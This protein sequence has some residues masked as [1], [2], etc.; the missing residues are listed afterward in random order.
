MNEEAL[1]HQLRSA[2]AH[3]HDLDYL[4]TH[5]L[6]QRLSATLPEGE[7][8]SHGLQ[9]RTVLIE[10][11]E[12]LKPGA[13]LPGWAPQWRR[14]VILHDRY[15]LRRP[16][17]EIEEKLSLGDRQVRREH[18]RAL[19]ALAV[20]VRLRLGLPPSPT[21]L[22][23]PPVTVQEA[24]QRLSP[25]PRVFGLSQLFEEVVAIL[26]EV[27]GQCSAVEWCVQPDE[28]TVYTD[29]GILHQLL[30]KLLRLFLRRGEGGRQVSLRAFSDNAHVTIVVTSGAIRIQVG[31]E[32]LRLC[33]WLAQA[34]RTEIHVEGEERGS[35]LSFVLPVGTRLRKV[36]IIDDEQ[37]AI[38]L[39]Q[40]YLNGLDYQVIGETMAEQ[41]L[42][43]AVETQPDAIVLD[44]MMP[45]VDGW[46]LLQRL[47]HTPQLRDVPIIVCSVL[48]DADLAFA[49]GAARFLRKPV[50]RQQ[51]VAVLQEACAQAPRPATEPPASRSTA[52]QSPS[53]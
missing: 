10:L 27:S 51:L 50:L 46:E 19:A 30:V 3:L 31:D 32:D 8:T 7:S 21:T 16:L 23:Q 20:L 13:E 1:L 22:P 34:L 45:A 49:L 9:L 26:A 37:P 35:R 24:V 29:R 40:S 12:S 53:D 28:L 44:V 2:L 36:L 42:Q 52:S 41:A 17:W 33:Q 39:F 38:E 25:T 5:P 14:Y 48:D 4:E 6:A 15:V 47:Y 11:I 18:H 43:R